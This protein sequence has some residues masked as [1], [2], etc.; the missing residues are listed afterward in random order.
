MN[1]KLIEHVLAEKAGMIMDYTLFY[2]PTDQN[3]EGFG[4]RVKDQRTKETITL[5][6]ISVN[7]LDSKRLFELVLRG[8]VTPVSLKDVVEDY[9]S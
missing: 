7:P 8:F 4:I 1:D 5:R 2:G 3:G 9:I 6:D